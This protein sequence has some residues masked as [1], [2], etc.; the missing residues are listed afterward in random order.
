MNHKV[1]RRVTKATLTVLA[2]SSLGNPIIAI[3]ETIDFNG[4]SFNLLSNQAQPVEDTAAASFSFAQ[5]RF[6]VTK[7]E[8]TTIPFQ[9]TVEVNEVSFELP[10]HVH[11]REDDL[12]SNLKASKDQATNQWTLTAAEATKTFALPM[13]FAAEGS[14]PITVG[15]G[16]TTVDVRST[17]TNSS[18]EQLQQYQKMMLRQ[19]L[20]AV[21][22]LRIGMRYCLMAVREQ[23]KTVAV[24]WKHS[25]I[26]VCQKSY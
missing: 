17:D 10:E 7:N 25:L 1:R 20:R 6:I 14:F 26:N 12:P 21:K 9:S 3:A 22:T 23:W 5:N 8:V 24:L 4:L 19:S 15:D 18:S 13:V 11:M 2:I 16:E